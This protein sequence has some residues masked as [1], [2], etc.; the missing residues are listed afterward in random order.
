MTRRGPKLGA[1]FRPRRYANVIIALFSILALALFLSCS[2]RASESTAAA[3][4]D[5]N[6]AKSTFQALTLGPIQDPKCLDHGTLSGLLNNEIRLT[7]DRPAGLNPDVN[8]K[9]R[10]TVTQGLLGG[11]SKTFDVDEPS[12]TYL[13]K[14]SGLI[15]LTIN[16][17]VSPFIE[18]WVGPAID[19]T[20]L[21]VSVLI[22]G[23]ELTCGLFP[24]LGSPAVAERAD[25]LPPS[26]VT[27]LSEHTAA[28]KSTAS[29]P[30]NPDEATKPATTSIRDEQANPALM[31]SLT[32]RTISSASTT[33][34]TSTQAPRNTAAAP[35][36]VP[37]LPTTISTSQALTAAIPRD[38]GTLSPTARL[39]DVEAITAREEDLVVVIDGD[40]VPTDARQGATALEIWLSGG[41]PGTTWSTFASEDPDEDGWRWA[42][43]NQKTGTVVYIR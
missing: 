14:P 5:S 39:E 17:S 24:L 15:N 32:T 9:Y 37:T 42:A 18:G 20:A 40:T 31:A 43:I 41:D 4:Q 2:L 16:L 22:L 30:P 38:P 19:G 27:S 8:I 33:E 25:R 10:I 36:S 35:T 1:T 29:T 28:S 6:D 34:P 12:F 13:W 7:W 11:N 26:T 23:V 21:G 3:W